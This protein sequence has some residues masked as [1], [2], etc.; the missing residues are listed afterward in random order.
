MPKDPNTKGR[1]IL[2]TQKAQETQGHESKAD[3]HGHG[4]GGDGQGWGE[5]D[6]AGGDGQGCLTPTG[7][8]LVMRRIWKWTGLHDRVNTLGGTKLYTVTGQR[9]ACDLYP[10]KTIKNTRPSTGV[11]EQPAG[12]ET[13]K[14][15]R[16]ALPCS[17][18]PPRASLPWTLLCAERRGHCGP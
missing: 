11:L 6:R 16:W 9:V 10:N 3:R 15:C 13:Q 2:C 7:S 12:P 18:C 17:P 14:Q 8:H 1:S 5:V 4:L